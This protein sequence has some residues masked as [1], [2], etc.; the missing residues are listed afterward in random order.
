M[1]WLVS[2]DFDDFFGL[3]RKSSSSSLFE[4]VLPEWLLSF[5]FDFF[6]GVGFLTE[7]ILIS[8][9]ATFFSVI[10][11]VSFE[12]WFFTSGICSFTLIDDSLNDS[13]IAFSR[14]LLNNSSTTLVFRLKKYDHLKM[15]LLI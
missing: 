4:T 15:S 12:T 14:S 13:A 6:V 5:D 3:T 1:V 2:F 9:I 7:L 11:S 10:V 8:V